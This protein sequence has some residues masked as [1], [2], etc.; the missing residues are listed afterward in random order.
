MDI[1]TFGEVI[2]DASDSLFLTIE[3][4]CLERL[5][6]LTIIKLEEFHGSETYL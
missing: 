1:G 5:L 6:F 4:L 3:S 2:T